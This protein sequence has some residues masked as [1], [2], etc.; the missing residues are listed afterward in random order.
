MSQDIVDA[1]KRVT[2]GAISRLERL[3]FKVTVEPAA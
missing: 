2:K 3:G 1:T